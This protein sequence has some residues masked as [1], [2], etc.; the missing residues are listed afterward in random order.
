MQ[1]QADGL[2][3]LSPL[4]LTQ[5]VN[6]L[7][8]RFQ[9]LRRCAHALVDRLR[10]L[11]R[12]CGQAPEQGLVPHDGGIPDG[13]GGGGCDL[14]ELL[15]ILRGGILP[16]PPLLHLVQDRH[17][18][19]D[20]GEI[21]HGVDGL[22]NLPVLLEVKILRLQE[23]NHIGHT[24]AVDEHGAQNR[25]LCLQGVG[26]LATQQFLLPCHDLRLLSGTLWVSFSLASAP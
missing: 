15:D 14:H 4:A 17:R 11:R 5:G 26:R 2:Q 24:P 12:R 3:A 20:L 6:L 23:A 1:H 16:H 7:F 25:L 8:R 22:V 21:E 18:V 13:V 19:D 10:N 9:N